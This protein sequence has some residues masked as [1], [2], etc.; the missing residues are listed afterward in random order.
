M[1]AEHIHSK[2]EKKGVGKKNPERNQE[3]REK[4][5]IQKLGQIEGIK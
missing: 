5:S 3:R 2:M 4:T 1:G